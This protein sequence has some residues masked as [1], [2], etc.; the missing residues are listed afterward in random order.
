[1]NEGRQ[2][3]D[4]EEAFVDDSGCLIVRG[5]VPAGTAVRLAP[6]RYKSPPPYV[7]V[8]VIG[9]EAAGAAGDGQRFELA[10]DLVGCWGSSG[11]EV[12][13]ASTSAQF[14]RPGRDQA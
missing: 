6:R 2:L 7:G 1:M 9:V 5:Q 12:V 10:L 13:G 4:F 11:V 3:V 14:T 8:E